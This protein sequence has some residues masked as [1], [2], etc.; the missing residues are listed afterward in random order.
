MTRTPKTTD[1]EA[2]KKRSRKTTTEAESGT[3]VVKAVKTAPKPAKPRAVKAKPEAEVVA[4]PTVQPL[5]AAA[6]VAKE[7][8]TMTSLEE[9]IRIRAYELYVRRGGRGGS[10]EQDWFEAAAEV[11]G[12]SVA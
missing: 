4:T 10:P 6:P 3:N 8:L 11:Y 5:A 7:I 9:R 1:G 12:E 2:P